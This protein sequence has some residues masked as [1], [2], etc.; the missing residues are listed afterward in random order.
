MI[1]ALHRLFDLTEPVICEHARV[2]RQQQEGEGK[3]G[4][5]GDAK[6]LGRQA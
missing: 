3:G 5:D 2:M 4:K 1:F 6:P